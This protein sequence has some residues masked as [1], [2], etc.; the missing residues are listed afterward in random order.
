[1][2]GVITAILF[3]TM[4]V[5]SLMIILFSTV[6]G[7]FRRSIRAYI[8]SAIL[9]NFWALGA[10]LL[11][12]FPIDAYS[13]AGRGLFIVA[14]M[15]VMY[16]LFVVAADYP[17]RIPKLSRTTRQLVFM[18]V[19]VA[20][21]AAFMMSERIIT[22]SSETATNL[23]QLSIN[24][25]WYMGYALFFAIMSSAYSLSFFK[26]II[27]SKTH[28]NQILFAYGGILVSSLVAFLTNLILPLFHVSEYIWVGP[29]SSFIYALS[30]AYA[31]KRYRLFDLR[32]F[33]TR[34]VVYVLALVVLVFIYAFVVGM[35]RTVLQELL[36]TPVGS[37]L[38]FTVMTVVTLFL[39]EPLKKIFDRYTKRIFFK[40]DY[41]IQDVI[42]KLGGVLLRAN[43]RQEIASRATKLLRDA[44]L[45]DT[46]TIIFNDNKDK[47]S[48][49]FM[50]LFGPLRS[51]AIAVDSQKVKSE[52]ASWMRDRDYELVSGITVQTHDI[53]WIV[54]GPKH[55]GNAY[56]DQD[57]SLIDIASDEIAI[58]M[59]NALQYEQ[60]QQFNTT[61]Q[62]KVK[63]ATGELR[64]TNSKL[65]AID[66]SKDEF[67]SMASHQLRTPL[68]SIKGY[69]SMLLEG[70]LGE[71]KPEQR[72]AL[73]EAYTSSQRMVYLIGDFLNLSRLQTG[74]FE[75]ERTGVSLP[76]IIR[77]EIAQLRATAQTRGI[78]LSY[79]EPVEFPTAS[80][81]E[82]KIRQ[83]MMNFIDNAIYYAKS[84]GGTI[85]V[86]LMHHDHEVVF[87]VKD[88][89][90]GVPAHERPH[91]FTKFYRAANARKAR[92][93]G[94]GIGLYM[95]KKVIVAHDGS[96][97]FES[98]EG[99]G[100]TFGFRLPLAGDEATAPDTKIPPINSG[101]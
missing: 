53:G 65:R 25:V 77:E 45:T 26:K 19:L 73:E 21:A 56:T 44:L 23:Y 97:I 67:I 59:E 100:S 80:V 96:I 34:A 38:F 1:M 47:L 14:P 61:L 82:N 60:I 4:I 62:A 13:G 3:A 32:R 76:M 98:K 41:T 84:S 52:L 7:E 48:D 87:K 51:G 93:D 101:V 69:I 27:A 68:T 74:R 6:G 95:A 99:E 29:T 35:M 71:I 46:A 5:N 2:P 88:N 85:V 33:A 75:L 42:D 55:S 94:T 22:G 18:M 72:K 37:D 78:E 30:Y 11:L 16:W 8:I 39:Y 57:M 91:L 64:D 10:L 54:L 12:I 49:E 40:N 83:V 66:A 86:S 9:A 81:D 90:I 24:P 70:D 63:D 31:M 89:G 79:E 50:K 43:T 36:Q 15:W 28:R 58:A 17:S 92:P 20:S